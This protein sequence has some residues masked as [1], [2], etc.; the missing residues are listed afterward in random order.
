MSSKVFDRFVTKAPFAVM[1]RALTQDFIGSDLQLVFDN[2]REK[3]YEYL[4]TFQAVAMTVADVALNFSENFNQ[5]YKE[6]KENLDVSRQSF[7]AKTRGISTS[8][9]V[10]RH[11]FQVMACR[12]PHRFRIAS[13]SAFVTRF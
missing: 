2:N 6:H 11:N 12:L 10:I 1:T 13:S 3:Q 4:A 8:A 7:Y 9:R 5:A